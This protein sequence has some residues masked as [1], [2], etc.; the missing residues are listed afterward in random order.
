MKKA[1]PVYDASFQSAVA[2]MR[3]Y[4]EQFPGLQQ[5]GRNGQ[6]RYNNQDHSMFTALRAARNVLGERLDIW[7]VNVDAEYHETMDRQQPRRASDGAALAAV[8]R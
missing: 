5:V 2:T 3:T 1:Y 8:S 4:L 7:D 6:H